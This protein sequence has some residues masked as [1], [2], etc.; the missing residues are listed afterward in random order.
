MKTNK[1]INILPKNHQRNYTNKKKIK[2]P[3]QKLFSFQGKLF[4]LEIQ[5]N[6]ITS[7]QQKNT[8]AHH[9]Q[10][11]LETT[12]SIFL[13]TH[14]CTNRIHLAEVHAIFAMN[15]SNWKH[16]TILMP[17]VPTT[18]KYA[19]LFAF[20]IIYS[21]PIYSI[22]PSHWYTT[23]HTHLTVSFVLLYLM[24]RCQVH[25]LLKHH[26]YILSFLCFPQYTIWWPF[27]LYLPQHYK[28]LIYP[29]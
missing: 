26:S 29:V 22:S 3:S 4:F 12:W 1:P 21:S 15:E 5:Y 6:Y 28:I 18:L 23:S 14:N 25:Y 11:I 9:N 27:L 24:F 2:T 17:Y 10:D 7:E 8:R 20:H 19:R 16:L 13:P